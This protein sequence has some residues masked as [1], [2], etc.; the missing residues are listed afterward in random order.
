MLPPQ[1]AS[2]NWVKIVQ[3]VPVRLEVDGGTGR[4]FAMPAGATVSV[5]I[6]TGR[7]VTLFD[8]V[9]SALAFMAPGK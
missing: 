2:G 1:N 4:P 8:A 6:D 3:R 5:S 9:G 7:E